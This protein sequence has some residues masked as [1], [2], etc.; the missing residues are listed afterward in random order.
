MSQKQSSQRYSLV[1][2]PFLAPVF[3]LAM[4]ACGGHES[5][6]T[7]ASSAATEKPVEVAPP[8]PKDVL[9]ITLGQPIDL[10]RCRHGRLEPTK[11]RCW[12]STD[13]KDDKPRA[14]DA[15]EVWLPDTEVP[16]GI[17][18]TVDVVLQDGKVYDINLMTMSVSEQ[19][20]FKML[21]AK[22]GK[23]YESNVVQM[24]NGFGAKYGSIEAHWIFPDLRML[25]SGR[26]SSTTEGSIIFQTLPR[27]KQ[28]DYPTSL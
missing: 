21:E 23:P 16:L 22:W 25:F 11:A 3:S 12:T 1:K 8:T 4:A 18:S 7:H 19:D 26:S 9:G 24:Q 6:A 17:F 2:T 5:G 10:P 15:I 27:P 14:D 20:I 28:S 13:A